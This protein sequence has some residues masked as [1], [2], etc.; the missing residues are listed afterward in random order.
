MK[1]AHH[2]S[3]NGLDDAWLRL[4]A[5]KLA[6]GSMGAGNEFGHP[7]PET[8]RRLRGAGVPL[9]RTDRDGTVTVVSDGQSW[10]QSVDRGGA[11]AAEPAG[12]AAASGW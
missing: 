2:G 6:V 9:D 7:H 3:R 1:L 5:P 8:L 11:V 10:S 4:V 12:A